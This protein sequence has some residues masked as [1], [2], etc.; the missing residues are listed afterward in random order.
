[1]YKTGMVGPTSQ[2]CV[3]NAYQKESQ[4]MALCR[5]SSGPFHIGFY[6]R[7]EGYFP[8]HRSVTAYSLILRGQDPV[9]QR[10]VIYKSDI[11]GQNTV[12]DH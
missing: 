10:L 4:Y 8:H 6:L 2:A 12:N 9:F 1:M 3:N 5:Y 7:P 11:I